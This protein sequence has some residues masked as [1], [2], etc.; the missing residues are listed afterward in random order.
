MNRREAVKLTGIMMSGMG[1]LTVLPVPM[2]AKDRDASNMKLDP[3]ILNF[4]EDEAAKVV[5][6]IHAGGTLKGGHLSNTSANL[7]LL[8]RH[9]EDS[10]CD[11][12]FKERFRTHGG[13]M[14]DPFQPELLEPVKRHY[15]EK[16]ILISDDDLNSF[17][18][19]DRWG[20][21]REEAKAL[22]HHHRGSLSK[23]LSQTSQAM[24]YYAG[25]LRVRE[26]RLNPSVLLVQR[27]FPP[28]YPGDWSGGYGYEPGEPCRGLQVLEGSLALLLAFAAAAC[29]I[30]GVNVALGIPAA[31]L[32]VIVALL[33]AIESYFC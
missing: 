25:K 33:A 29:L 28:E 1:A 10:G 15:K 20:R 5:N 32:G 16:H 11:E 12:F 14:D 30:P 6:H 21:H 4:V 17:V 3:T 22:L 27:Q 18:R 9:L 13:S 19:G 23:L 26:A 7:R 2:F 8:S 31:I 24:E